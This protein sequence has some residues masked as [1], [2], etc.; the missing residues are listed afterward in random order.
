M[1][2]RALSPQGI[3]AAYGISERGEADIN[4]SDGDRAAT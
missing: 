3:I 1:R 2:Q 4:E